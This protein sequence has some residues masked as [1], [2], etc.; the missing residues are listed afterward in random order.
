[1]KKKGPLSGRGNLGKCVEAKMAYRACRH[2]QYG[3]Q[4][5]FLEEIT[6]DLHD[7]N[8]P[9]IELGVWSSQDGAGSWCSWPADCE[10]QAAPATATSAARS[11]AASTGGTASRRGPPARGQNPRVQSQPAQRLGGQELRGARPAPSGRWRGPGAVPGPGWTS[12]RAWRVGSGSCH[13]I[14]KGVS[15][16]AGSSRRWA[17]E[18]GSPA[19]ISSARDRSH[20]SPLLLPWGLG[21]GRGLRS[22]PVVR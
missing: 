13:F 20:C 17:S 22:S 3:D 16:E 21:R 5:N 18:G 9:R 8:Y 7:C 4:R 2:T 15:R 14:A 11:G 19:T 10:Q 1:M 6:R 12:Q